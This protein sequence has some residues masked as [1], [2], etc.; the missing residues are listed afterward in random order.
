MNCN[1]Y[2]V[3]LMRFYS[4]MHYNTNYCIGLIHCFSS[5]LVAS[6]WSERAST[7]YALIEALILR[8]IYR[9]NLNYETT[10]KTGAFF[11]SLSLKT[12]CTM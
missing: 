2:E 1:G 10:S 9:V 12:A 4:S 8:V 5:I 11:I 6:R 3:Y 7:N